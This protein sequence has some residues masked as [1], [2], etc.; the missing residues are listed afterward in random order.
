[1]PTLIV[2]EGPQAGKHYELASRTL[3]L[4]RDPSRDIQLT[5]PKVSRKHAVIRRTDDGYV[6]ALTKDLNGLMIGDRPVE[7]AALLVDGD[8]IR[9]GDTSLRFVV[10]AVASQVNAVHE[11]KVADRRVRDARTI[12]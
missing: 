4:G 11:W 10:D 9:I 6:V 12:M 2:T 8:T 5:D 1:M 3:S 7:G